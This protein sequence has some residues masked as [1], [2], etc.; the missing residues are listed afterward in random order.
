MN[1]IA[2]A[3]FKFGAGR[4]LMQQGLL[5][6]AGDEIG[7]YG[8]KPFIVGGPTAIGIVRERLDIGL[9][10]AGLTG[11]YSIHPGHVNHA[12]ARRKAEEGRAQGCDVV[13]A[14][15]G[16]RAMDFGKLVAYYMDSPVV[17]VPTTISTCAAYSPFSVTYTPEGRTIPGNFCYDLENASILVDMDVMARQP[18]RYVVAGLLDAMGKF[19]E[20]KNGHRE[21]P[22][23]GTPMSLYAGYLLTKY[24]FERLEALIDPVLEDLKAHRVSQALEDMVF[25]NIPLTG[26]ISGL[27]RGVGQSAIAHDLYYQV[28]MFFPAQSQKAVHGEIVGLGIIPQLYYNGEPEKC[29]PFRAFLKRLGAP[30]CLS[31]IGVEPT[32]ENFEILYKATADSIYVA[33]DEA[34]RTRFREALTLIKS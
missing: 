18:A 5:E 2:D 14:V 23:S 7:R 15:G 3:S 10:K 8:K 12:D 32:D 17:C 34:S 16:G 4:Y 24:T 28:R 1:G 27:S 29:E 19:V 31:E 30:T 6:I 20:I 13:V 25:I 11:T 22:V 21:M 26:I 33:K 9:A